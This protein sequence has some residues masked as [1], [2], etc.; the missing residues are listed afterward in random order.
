ML[1]RSRRWAMKSPDLGRPNACRSAVP[2]SRCAGATEDSKLA[3]SIRAL[4]VGLLLVVASACNA[5]ATAPPSG[6]ATPASPSAPIGSITAT[7]SAPAQS[8]EASQ[9]PSGEI[10]AASPDPCALV[11]SE[12]ASQLAGFSIGQGQEGGTSDIRT[13]TFGDPTTYVLT[14]MVSQAATVAAAQ[15]AQALAQ[16]AGQQQLG[17]A[18]TQTALPAVGGGATEL[19]GTYQLNDTTWSLSAIYALDRTVFFSIEV[20]AVGPVPSGQALEDQAAVIVR[21][22]P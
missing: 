18:G 13:C 3:E 2:E 12:E 4:V 6:T 7:P 20:L 5:T 8:Q 15:A 11:T 10:T 22:L 19:L 17:N 9:S 1:T 21:R 14:V 16:G